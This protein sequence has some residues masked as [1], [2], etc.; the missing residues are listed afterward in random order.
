MVRLDLLGR[1]GLGRSRLDDVGI[2]RALGQEVDLADLGR[3]LL[4]H[5]DELVADDPA[6]LLRVDYLLE[7]RQEA[8]ASV[9]HHQV[10]AQVVCKGLAQELR[11]ALAHQAVVDVDARQLVADGAV[12]ERRGNGRVD[13]AGQRAD[14]LAIADA[15]ADV[16]DRASRRSW[17]TSTSDGPGRCRGRSCAG[18]RGRPACG[19]PRDGTGCRTCAGRDRPVPAYGVDAGLRQAARNLLAG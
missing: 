13:A 17:P 1:L 16:G 10:H 19:P 15:S 3:L 4:E 8:V 12:D 11:F 5:P 2:E 9:D 6:L 14:D 18:C 7:P